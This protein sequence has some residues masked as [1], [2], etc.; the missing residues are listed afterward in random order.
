MQYVCFYIY[1]A[2]FNKY[3]INIRVGKPVVTGNKKLND[4][5][6]R[7]GVNMAGVVDVI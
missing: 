5:F 2:I 1:L 7:F 4:V 3:R 6:A